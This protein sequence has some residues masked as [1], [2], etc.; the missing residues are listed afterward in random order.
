MKKLIAFCLW[1]LVLS[2]HAQ[3]DITSKYIKNPSFEQDNASSLSAVNNSADGL[4]GYTLAQPTGWTVSDPANVTKLLVTKDCYSDN[5]FGKVTTIPNGT[6]AYYLRMGWSTGSTSLT[7][8][9]TLPAGNYRLSVNQRTGYANNAVSTLSLTAGSE[10]VGIPFQSGSTGC[11]TSMAWTTSS[12]D[13]TLSATATVSIGFSVTWQS[14]GSCVML[15]NVK[16]YQMPEPQPDPTEADVTSPTEGVITSDFVGEAA[17][18]CDLLQMLAD[19]STYI[20]NDWQEAQAP[21]S[22][23]EAC[24]CFK[25]ENTMANDER[26]VRPN[27]DLSMICAFL[28]KYGKPAGVTLPQGV[29]WAKLEE[30]AMKSLV[31]AYSTHKANK[32]KVCSGN[33]YWGSTSTSDAVWESSLWAMSVAYSAY[34]QWD[35]LTDNQK[36]YIYQLLKAECNYELYRS[37]PTGYSGDTKA[38]ENGWEADVLAAALGL[39][40]N[41]ALAPKWFERLREFAI[42]SYSHPNDIQNHTVIDSWYDPKTYADLY[43]GQNLYDDYTL[44]NHNLFHTS[45]QNVVMQ[46]LGEAALALKLFQTGL[47]GTEKWKTN[48]LMHNNQEVQDQVLNWLAL[49]DGELAMPNGNDWSLFLYDQITS[50]STQACFQRDPNA[51]MLENLAYKYIK[52]RQKTTADGSWLLRADV[53]ARRMGVEAHRVM[54]TFLMHHALSTADLT[55]TAWDDFRATH[56]EA[57]VLPCQNVVRAFTKDRFTTFSWSTGL[58]NYTG[59]IAS[60]SVDQNKIIVPYRANGTGNFLGWYTVGGKSTNATPVVSGIYQLMGDAYTM[61]GELNTNDATLNNRFVLY[62]TPGNAVVYLDE[63]KGLAS[64]TITGE[65]G[66][67][68]AISVDDMTRLTR[69]LYYNDGY[70]QSDGS[71]LKQWQTNWLNVDN[72]L[73]IVSLGDKAMAFGD[74]ANNN[75][76]MTAKLYPSYSNTSRSFSN[77]TVVDRRNVTYYSN[78]TAEQT[79]QLESQMQ[80][81]TSTVPT[82]WNGIIAPDPDGIHYLLLAHFS[83]T[84][85]QTTLTDIACPLGAPVFTVPTAISN[86]KATGTFTVKS[87]NNSFANVLKIF[88]KGIN[89]TALQ[90]ADDDEVAYLTAT[91]NGTATVSIVSG[92]QTLT[93]AISLTQGQTLKVWV[94]NGAIQTA[95]S[96][97]PPA[98]KP[99]SDQTGQIVNPDFD[100]NR[101]TG[102]S[103]TAMTADCNEVEKWNDNFDFHQTV[104]GLPAGMYELTMQG[105]YR[106][107]DHG[108]AASNRANG[109]ETI[110][111]FL[112]ARTATQNRSTPLPSIFDEAGKKGALGVNTTQG[113]IPDNM[114]QAASYFAAGLYPCKLRVT[115]GDDGTLTIGVKKLNLVSHDWTIFDHFTLR[116]LGNG[117]RGD[118]NQDND[119]NISDVTELVNVILGKTGENFLADVNE[120]N[121]ANISDVTE[122]VNIILGKAPSTSDDDVDPTTT[123]TGE[124]W[125]SILADN[126]PFTMLSLP[127]A[128]DAATK[129]TSSGTTETQSCSIAELLTAGVRALDLRPYATNSTTADNMYIYHGSANTNVLFMD[130]L[131]TVSSFLDSHPTETVFLLLHEEDGNNLDAWRTATLSCLNAQSSHIKPIDSNMTLDQCRG[132]MVIIA[133]DNVGSTNLCGKCGWGSSFGDKTVF[134]GS[135][136]NGTTPWTLVYQDEYDWDSNY[137]T[138]RIAN[139]EKLLTNYIQPN[140]LKANR[141]YVNTANVAWSWTTILN[142]ASNITNTA[143]VV[144]QAILDSPTFQN[145]T[146]RWGI[147]MADYMAD[148]TYHGDQLLQRIIQQNFRHLPTKK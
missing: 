135:D 93:K 36:N 3:E 97:L 118:L 22:V 38:E 142:G 61:N 106:E 85:T 66:G 53:G 63:V 11:F 13:F 123:V 44:Q 86:G 145:S 89:I 17:M 139:L 122:L 26:G 57:R 116:Y 103:G 30:L 52:A 27:A 39:F 18:K 81:L 92:G 83:G 46:E 96:A 125:M 14:G 54:M 95:A 111:S 102:W 24:G 2:V 117:L 51:L 50:Y 79:A 88:V 47:Y 132:K 45:Y 4:R 15:D 75:S 143:P 31:F 146:G 112:Y 7:Q 140:E 98:I 128:H 67:L 136:S 77:G 70:K 23:G 78:V 10:S 127:G 105:F 33:N 147:L 133:R 137:A 25:G 43:K 87:E 34:F 74:R 56:S 129:G 16:L 90:D 130:A 40:P 114:E 1:A 5:N 72:A 68:M 59:Y 48:A 124:N 108:P 60:N 62:S 12:I 65:R 49:T 35:K 138:A 9:V 104:T 58:K 121:S 41:D 99:G 141:I 115:V 148:P 71:A 101:T 37:I 107:G 29:T 82:G 42:N 32:L 120:D 113:Y 110:N 84:T 64:G 20:V 119:V 69:T 131:A 134:K 21:N 8:K 109:K 144:N 91:A 73:G 28:V 80:L 100:G 126:I 6:Y 94:K 19:F 76:I 55:P